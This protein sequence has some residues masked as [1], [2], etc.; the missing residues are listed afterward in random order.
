[1][2]VAT[3]DSMLVMSWVRMVEYSSPSGLRMVMVFSRGSSS[4]RRSGS[5]ARLLMKE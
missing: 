1:M 2:L 3:T 5:I 4:F